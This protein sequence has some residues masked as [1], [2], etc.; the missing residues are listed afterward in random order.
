M[1]S[2]LQDKKVT[3]HSQSSLLN[4]VIWK[5]TGFTRQLWQSRTGE[6]SSRL[7]LLWVGSFARRFAY[8]KGIEDG[9]SVS[10]VERSFVAIEW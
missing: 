8:A 10:R 7:K 2:F 3:T 9:Q 4:W 1:T 5:T 6:A